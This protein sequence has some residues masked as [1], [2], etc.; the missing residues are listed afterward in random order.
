[1][2]F[3][4]LDGFGGR[5]KLSFYD[6]ITNVDHEWM[7]CIGVP[8]GTSLWQVVDSKEQNGSFK[9]TMSKIKSKISKKRLNM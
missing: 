1:M 5:F 2:L 6:Y 7:V 9:I 3:R 4:S 8:C